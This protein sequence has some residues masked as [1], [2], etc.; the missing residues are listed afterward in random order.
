MA[1]HVRQERQRRRIMLRRP[2]FFKDRSNPLE[3]LEA[4]EV[5]CRYRF[6]P[7]TIIHILQLIVAVEHPTR[8][9]NLLTL[10]L[11]VHLCLRFLATGSMHLLIGDSLNVSRSTAGRCIRDVAERI[12]TISNEHVRFPV[13]RAADEIKTA[14]SKVAGFK[15]ILVFT[16]VLK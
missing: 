6:R 11:Q 8:R 12:A 10:L 14:F 3:D 4:D 5:F 1:A 16:K 13:G 2:R 9:N 7:P 15:L